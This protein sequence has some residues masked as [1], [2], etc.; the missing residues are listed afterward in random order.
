MKTIKTDY[1]ARVEGEGGVRI[2]FHGEEVRDVQVRIFEP[3]RFFEA[4]LCGR[5]YAEVPDITA[6]ICGI[7]PV[8]YQMS[9][10]AAMEDA[11]ELPITKAI[12]GLRRIL[13]CGEWIESH[14]LHVFMLHAPDFLGYPDAIAMAREHREIVTAGLAIKKAGNAIV[15]L[16][17][18]REI[19]PVNVRVGGFHSMP[20]VAAMRQ[21]LPELD[22]ARQAALEVLQWLGRLEYPDYENDYEFVAVDEGDRYPFTGSRIISN[23][24]LNIAVRD[25]ESHFEESQVAH[26][27]A[28]H[29]RLRARGRYVCGPL[30]RFNLHF[31]KLSRDVREAARRVN[32][33]PPCHNPF[34]SIMVRAVEIAFALEQAMALIQLYEDTGDACVTAPVAASIGYG[35]SEAPRGLLYHRYRIDDAGIIRA[36]KIVPPTSQNLASIEHDLARIA[37]RMLSMTHPAATLL[38]EQAVRNY[39]P[40]ISCATHFV[41]LT[42]EQE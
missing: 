38:A 34:K 30:A 16:I 25:Y 26:S 27:N 10:C 40:C 31:D 9:S 39:D 35:A 3:P 15:R 28:L 6:R 24:G 42:I 17:G 13:Y 37:P 14:A 5:S 41:R 22:R 11:L 4:F 7:C 23:R 18:G 2:R 36:A 33:A 21:L 29:A 12:A 19:H 1:L 8:A 20:A 32:L